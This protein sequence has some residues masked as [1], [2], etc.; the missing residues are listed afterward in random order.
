VKN[1]FHSALRGRSGYFICANFF[2]SNFCSYISFL[3]QIAHSFA[4]FQNFKFLTVFVMVVDPGVQNSY[5]S[6]FP[7]EIIVN[8]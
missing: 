5:F 3:L 6:Q 7:A 2:N 1:I 4:R 8:H